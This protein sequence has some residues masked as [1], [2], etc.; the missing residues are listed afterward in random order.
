MSAFSAL[1]P[2]KE[3]TDAI[4][5]NFTP[6]PLQGTDVENQQLAAWQALVTWE[7]SNPL[8]LDAASVI[9]RVQFAYRQATTS[10]RFFSEIWYEAAMYMSEVGRTDDA[11]ALFKEGVAALPE[12]CVGT[13]EQSWERCFIWNCG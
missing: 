7:R 11:V 2:R 3:L 10:L 1:K 4:K 8:M 6:R 12:R 13:W 5:R 9:A